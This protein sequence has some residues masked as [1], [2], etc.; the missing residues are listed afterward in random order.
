MKTTMEI[1]DDLIRQAKVLA[2]DRG[3]TFRAL[4]TEGLRRVLREEQV[5]PTERASRVFEVMDDVAEYSATSRMSR[6]EA[7]ER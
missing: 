1:P 3:T 6:E 4:V 7:H 5:S 2:A